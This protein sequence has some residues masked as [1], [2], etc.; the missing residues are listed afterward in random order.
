MSSGE[1]L[2]AV[3]LI[4]SLQQPGEGCCYYYTPFKEEE[5]EACSLSKPLALHYF[6]SLSWFSDSTSD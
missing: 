5:A 4:V 2:R 1:M 6:E 3:R